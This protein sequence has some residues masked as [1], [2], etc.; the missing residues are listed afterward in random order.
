VPTIGPTIGQPFDAEEAAADHYRLLTH[1]LFPH[2]AFF[3]DSVGLL[4]GEMN[5]QIEEAYEQRGYRVGSPS[6][7]ADHIGHELGFLAFLCAA[8]SGGWRNR[9]TAV[10]IEFRSLQQSF[11]EDHLLRWITPLTVAIR[12]QSHAFYTELARLTLALLHDHYADLASTGNRSNGAPSAFIL[13]DNLQRL[14]DRA[15]SLRDVVRHLLAPPYSGFFLGRDAI[16]NVGRQLNLPIG[17]GNR[18]D[19]LAT[20]LRT[21]GQY[22]VAPGCLDALSHVTLAWQREYGTAVAEFPAFAPFIVP[23]QERAGETAALLA[24]FAAQW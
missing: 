15:T 4:G 7:A 16:V 10:A 12:F 20:L 22:E 5:R 3:L 23:W 17:F 24:Q 9:E 6:D 8:E 21:G 2:Q 18:E 14:N 19:L 1:A 11:L 13:P